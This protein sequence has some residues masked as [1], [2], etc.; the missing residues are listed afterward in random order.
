MMVS[1][2]QRGGGLCNKNLKIWFHVVCVFLFSNVLKSNECHYTLHN[3]NMFLLTFG[4]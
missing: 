4:Y 2:A 3:H 1:C